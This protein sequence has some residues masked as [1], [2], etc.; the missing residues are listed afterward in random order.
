VYVCVCVCREGQLESWYFSSNGYLRKKQVSRGLRVCANKRV[1]VYF[2]MSVFCVCVYACACVCVCVRVCVGVCVCVYVC[3]C[4]CACVCV[5]VAYIS[6]TH[7]Y[8]WHT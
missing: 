1:S 2:C 4:V 5:F 3:V 7:N 8:V 6:N